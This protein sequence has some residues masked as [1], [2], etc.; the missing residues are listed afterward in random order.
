[1][2]FFVSHP[3]LMIFILISMGKW[4]NFLLHPL[5]HPTCHLEQKGPAG[6]RHDDSS[7]KTKM[8]VKRDKK[9]VFFCKYKFPLRVLRS[10]LVWRNDIH[11]HLRWF[12]NDSSS[13]SLIYC[14][15]NY[16]MACKLSNWKHN[17]FFCALSPSAKR[18]I[19]NYV[20][21][22]CRVNISHIRSWLSDEGRMGWAYYV[23]LMCEQKPIITIRGINKRRDKICLFY[24]VV[25]PW[26]TLQSSFEIQHENRYMCFRLFLFSQ[27]ILILEIM[28]AFQGVW[29]FVLNALNPVGRSWI[30]KANIYLHNR[31]IHKFYLST[32]RA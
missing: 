22:S 3:H 24:F 7:K 8:K 32:K 20:F 10:S 29:R 28:A 13:R 25:V 11:N 12:Q 27:L 26:K 21:V 4:S 15:R 19:K 6:F 16:S 31:Q 17:F 23:L 5:H 2:F 1:M 14:P 18:S 30:G 9:K